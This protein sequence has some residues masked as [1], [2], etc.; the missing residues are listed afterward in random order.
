MMELGKKFKKDYIGAIAKKKKKYI[1]LNVKINVKL[2]RVTMKYSKEVHRSIQLRFIDSCRLVASSLYKLATNLD[3][4]Q[5]Q[6]LR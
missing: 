4:D 3:D 2:V 6:N 5:Y 1:S